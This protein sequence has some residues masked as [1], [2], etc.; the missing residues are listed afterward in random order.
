MVTAAHKAWD[1]PCRPLASL[2]FVA[3]ILLIYEIGI[4]VVGLDDARNGADLWLRSLLDW[5]G[6]GQYFLLPLLTCS[7]LLAWHHTT[8]Q[9]WA[10]STGV[11][12]R[13]FV[14]TCVF[15]LVLLFMAQAQGQLLAATQ[16]LA[17]GPTLASTAHSRTTAGIV[18]YLGA[19]LYEELLFRLMLL[20]V[21][22]AVFGIFTRSTGARVLL[23]IVA[24]SLLFAAAHYRID[25]TIGSW[26][27][28]TG[29]GEPFDG[30]SFAFRW[31]AGSLFGVLFVY[32]G[33]GIA[34]GTHAMYDILAVV[35]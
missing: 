21:L 19:G 3:P 23:A 5:L 15:A 28:V 26:H 34:V 2:A 33:F 25:L 17:D 18:G 12:T 31:L 4:L 1:E 13:M 8:R 24:S 27:L 9:S 22:S 14:E 29:H 16:R 30:F 11:V 35:F 32:R 20:P 10:L 7:I 6:F